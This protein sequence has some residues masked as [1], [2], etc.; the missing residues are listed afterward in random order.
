MQE[1]WLQDAYIVV[2]DAK[3]LEQL[4]DLI[5][6]SA[7]DVQACSPFQGRACSCRMS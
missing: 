3:Q 4:R 7:L 2:K 1:L 6:R 5:S